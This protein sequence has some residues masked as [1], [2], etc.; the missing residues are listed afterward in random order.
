MHCALR[1]VKK[2]I[3]FE[4]GG[5]GEK[6]LILFESFSQMESGKVVFLHWLVGLCTGECELWEWSRNALSCG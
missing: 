1:A 3:V 4:L 6:G 5:F 2:F